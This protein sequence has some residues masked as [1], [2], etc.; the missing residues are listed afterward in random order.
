MGKIKSTEH[1]TK[2]IISMVESGD[3]DVDTIQHMIDSLVENRDR[4]IRQLEKKARPKE[5][6][7]TLKTVS[8]ALRE[9]IRQHG[10]ITPEWIGS[11]AKRIYGNCQQL[12]TEPEP[13]VKTEAPTVNVVYDQNVTHKLTV[14]RDG[15]I[16]IKIAKGSTD[17]VGDHII[18][19]FKKIAAKALKL[20]MGTLRGKVKKDD[21]HNKITLYTDSKKE[22]VTFDY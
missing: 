7:M 5:F 9:T 20:N 19:A 6:N 12:A 3:Y 21:T 11:A 2:R 22:F 18:E 4:R 13:V 1:T 16:R 17:V 15:N 10:P 8:G 14:A